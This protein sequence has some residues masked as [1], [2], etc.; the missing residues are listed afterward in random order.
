M[1]LNIGSVCSDCLCCFIHDLLYLLIDHWVKGIPRTPRWYLTAGGKDGEV[2]LETKKEVKPNQMKKQLWRRV[3]YGSKHGP[4][5]GT[6]FNFINVGHDLAL[7]ATK[8]NSLTLKG[9]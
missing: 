7:T 5:N 4:G 8:E 1:P 3:H 2:T 9:K 6:W